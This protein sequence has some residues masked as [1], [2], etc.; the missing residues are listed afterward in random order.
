MGAVRFRA[1]VEL[2]RHWRGSVALAVL[3]GIGGGLA[4]A[5]FAGAR[6]TDTAL[7][8]FVAGAGQQPDATIDLGPELD[9]IRAIANLPRVTRTARVTFVFLRPPA[10]RS[11][12]L[13]APDTIGSIVF[14]D[15]GRPF[16]HGGIVVAGRVPDALAPDEVAID[17]AAA[18]RRGWQVGDRLTF[19]VPSPDEFSGESGVRASPDDPTI[20]LTVTGIVRLPQDLE[21]VGAGIEQ[22]TYRAPD[23]MWLTP[24]FL[25]AHPDAANGWAFA[26]VWLAGGAADLKAFAETVRSRSGDRAEVNP[27]SQG[28]TADVIVD[29]ERAIHVQA[30]ALRVAAAL[31]IAAVLFAAGLALSRQIRAGGRDRPTLRT[32]GMT[33][34]QQVGLGIAR[35]AVVALI[36]AAVAL[37]TAIALSSNFPV[38]FARRAEADPGMRLD[39]PVFAAG[40]LVLVVT[41]AAWSAFAARRIA[42][43][44]SAL[45]GTDTP[46]ARR[47]ASRLGRSLGNS[48]APVTAVVGV[49]MA[50]DS[51]RGGG[52]V[53]VRAAVATM[54]VV[55]AAVVGAVVF[56][57]SLAHLVSTPSLQGWRW[58][59]LVMG[60][61]PHRIGEQ[62]AD[63]RSSAAVADAVLAP[64]GID[65]HEIA[66]LAFRPIV[67]GGFPQIVDGREPAGPRDV[68]LGAKTMRTLGASIGDR[69]TA[70]YD[71]GSRR[72]T[73]VMRVVGRA[74]MPSALGYPG[75]ALAD[76]ALTTDA[77]FTKLGVRDG[78]DGELA[79][80]V[81]R[82]SP[83]TD[84]AARATELGSSDVITESPRSAEVENL[85]RVG[86]VPW[87]VVALLGA[88]AAA[89]IAHL[90]LTTVSRRRRDLA[91]LRA[92]G[93]R[94]RQ[95]VSTVVWQASTVTVASV[96]A[97]IPIG[98]VGGRWAWSGV[99][100]SLGVPASVVTPVV[101]LLVMVAGMLLLAI[102]VTA[103]PAWFTAR[104]HPA[105]V[106]RS[107]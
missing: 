6:R 2:R 12:S 28:D 95:V 94:R 82:F 54:T 65:G 74:V 37:L 70:A 92:L 51:R 14:D 18:R 77:A 56:A 30:N 88:V 62:L 25:D 8:R 22:A 93:F 89:T 90:L 33:D 20:D 4:L 24:A 86:G 55:V 85:R 45:P 39:L 46:P 91:L 41:L 107:D 69:V 35:G 104:R 57:T 29:A 17:E 38:G 98:V 9:S 27:G 75:M 72:R 105:V 68:A 79:F 61:D 3:T 99:A 87:M 43:S 32:L 52:A 103:V 66:T 83:G 80:V 97:G 96:L 58:D 76:G 67:G 7:D 21:P 73:L 47:R 59:V 5:T 16:L 19:G 26:A 49:G 13:A 60:S 42:F 50:L 84:A 23:D 31:A 11:P 78:Q 15:P 106:L 10:A 34:G 101:T 81:A 1:A 100:Q 71:D 48:G 40:V 102:A 63:D 44:A 53:P 64:V 36:A